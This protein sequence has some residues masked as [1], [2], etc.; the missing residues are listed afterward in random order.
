[1]ALVPLGEGLPELYQFAP[2][3]PLS[4]G[5]HELSISVLT[6]EGYP[7]NGDPLV[8]ETRSF[9][10]TE[11]PVLE[12]EGE[13]VAVTSYPL[14]WGGPQRSTPGEALEGDCSAA[15]VELTFG[16]HDMIPESTIRLDLSTNASAK[17]Y[18]VGN[19]LLPADCRVFFPYAYS[20]AAQAPFS[21]AAIVPT[22]LGPAKPFAGNPQRLDNPPGT[23][24]EKRPVWCSIAFG[25][26]TLEGV[27][28][29]TWL[30]S[31]ALFFMRR[32][33]NASKG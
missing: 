13:I 20:Q 24:R 15:A 23:F 29:L 27:W 19:Y 1:V 31:A 16:C 8:R 14:L 6:P 21:I 7:R 3:E 4:L 11:Q 17:G 10:V 22:G 33:L 25:A 26:S 30:S 18:V 28:S 32:R 2:D 12:A 5:P 9:N